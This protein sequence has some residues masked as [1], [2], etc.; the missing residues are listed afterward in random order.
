[1]LL[2]EL[3]FGSSRGLKPLRSWSSAGRYRHTAV[4]AVRAEAAIV[5]TKGQ[6][7][8]LGIQTYPFHLGLFVFLLF[9]FHLLQHSNIPSFQ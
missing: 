3:I 2:E 4:S 5:F 7:G 9:I 6:N 1:M 8:T